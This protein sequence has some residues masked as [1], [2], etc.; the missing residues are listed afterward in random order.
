[1]RLGVAI[2]GIVSRCVIFV[3]SE[4]Q[5]YYFSAEAFKALI[6]SSITM[7]GPVEFKRIPSLVF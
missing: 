1:V 3:F 4:H 7:L 6:Y 2:K 5:Q